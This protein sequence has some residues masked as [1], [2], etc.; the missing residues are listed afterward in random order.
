MNEIRILLLAAP[1]PRRM[2]M[3]EGLALQV[4]QALGRVVVA[5]LRLRED[6]VRLEE[7]VLLPSRLEILVIRVLVAGQ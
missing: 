1:V 7:V 2:A 4:E 3:V 5:I 6:L